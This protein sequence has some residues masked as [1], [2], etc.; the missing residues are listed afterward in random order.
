VVGRVLFDSPTTVGRRKVL[1]IAL[2]N[3]FY[4]SIGLALLLFDIGT[5]LSPIAYRI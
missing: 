5:T 3:S 2:S 1:F 4:T